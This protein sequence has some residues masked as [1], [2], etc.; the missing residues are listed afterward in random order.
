MPNPSLNLVLAGILPLLASCVSEPI[1]LAP[2]GPG[3]VANGAA[4]TWKGDL[5]VYT[6]TEEFCEDEMSW[7][8]HTDYQIYT[9]DGKRLKRVWNHQNHQDESPA[10][11]TLPPGKYVVQAQAQFYGRVIVPVVI[12]PGETTRVIL[13]PGWKPGK[14]IA[15]SDLV[16]IPN[17]YAVGWRA[18]LPLNQ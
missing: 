3:P 13:Q 17:G 9:A 4:S 12:K 14:E 16:Q 1:A 11:V 8:P 7:F 15:R 10:V 2:V 6:E 18:E 5:E